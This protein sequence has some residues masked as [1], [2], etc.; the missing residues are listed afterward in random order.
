MPTLQKLLL[1][2]SLATLFGLK[3]PLSEARLVTAGTVNCDVPIFNECPAG[4]VPDGNMCKPAPT[5]NTG[6]GGLGASCT[7]LGLVEK[8]GLCYPAEVIQA[9]EGSLA[10]S[11][12]IG[13]LI[14]N[15]INIL[16]VLV[17]A[18][19]VLF[20]V[21]GAVM[22]LSSA[23]NSGQAEKGKKTMMMAIFGL[24]AAAMAYTLTTIVYNLVT[25]GAVF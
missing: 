9:Q 25:K 22:Y 2:L 4:C 13:D 18:L 8:D 11:R 10:S 24:V 14:K 1:V 19:S 16:L 7:A 20:V 3:S 21:I 23:G 6:G 12:N 15:I 5:T 17:G